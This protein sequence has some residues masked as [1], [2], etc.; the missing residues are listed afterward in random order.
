LNGISC[1]RSSLA[2]LKLFKEAWKREVHITPEQVSALINELPAVVGN[3]VELAIFTD[4]HKENILSLRID[5]VRFY[6]TVPV[7][8]YQPAGQDGILKTSPSDCHMNF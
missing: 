4:F 8:V 1:D 5:A 7:G 6:D 2:G 3:I